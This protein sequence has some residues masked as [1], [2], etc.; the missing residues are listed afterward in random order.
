MKVMNWRYLKN[1]IINSTGFRW[2]IE[3]HLILSN[4]EFAEDEETLEIGCGMGR[5]AP[6]MLKRGIRYVGIDSSIKRL[7]IGKRETKYFSKRGKALYVC[8]DAGCLPFRNDQFDKILCN[9]VLEH[10]EDDAGVVR[11]MRRVLRPN[12]T[13]IL[14]VPAL[15]ELSRGVIIRM[16]CRLRK[17]IKP[18]LLHRFLWDIDSPEKMQWTLNRLFGHVNCYD[19][20]SLCG[21]CMETGFIP[22]FRRYY[23]QGISSLILQL[24]YVCSWALR[25]FPRTASWGQIVLCYLFWL[26]S[27]PDRLLPTGQPGYGILIMAA[28]TSDKKPG[29]SGDATPEIEAAA[30]T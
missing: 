30:V 25:S 29:K 1:R 22:T 13:L 17:E 12:G 14:A 8:G 16:A 3:S 7:V 26:L 5:M 28:K 19:M 6:A 18:Y 24:S 9:S 27:L 23:F 11:E 4:A 10:I 2:R 15:S 21:L 20:S